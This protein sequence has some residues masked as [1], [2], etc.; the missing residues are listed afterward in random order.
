[1]S[2][3]DDFKPGSKTAQIRKNTTSQLLLSNLSEINPY[4]AERAASTNAQML[5][6]DMMHGKA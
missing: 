6:R 2:D 5:L 3:P 4:L 1:M